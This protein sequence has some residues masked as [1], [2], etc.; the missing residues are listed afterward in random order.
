VGELDGLK[1][2][3]NE[4]DVVFQAQTKSVEKVVESSEKIS[5]TVDIFIDKQKEFNN[6]VKEVSMGKEILIE[7]IRNIATVGQEAFAIT[8]EVA[9]LTIGQRTVAD[10][11]LKISADICNKIN[12]MNKYSAKI[13]I[14]SLDKKRKKIAMIWDLES[15]FWDPATKEAHKAAKV[16]DFEISIFA[17][18]VRG[19]QGT[20]QM[21]EHLEE[22]IEQKYDAIVISPITNEKITQV[23][24]KATNQGIKI[25]FIQSVVEGV[26]YEAL[27]G[28][29]GF[30]CGINAARVAKRLLNNE[31]QAVIGM[32]AD[33]KLKAIEERAQGFIKELQQNSDI[34]VIQTDVVGEP[35]ESKAEDIIREMLRKH[36]NIDL[37]YATNVGWGMAYAKYVSK[38]HPNIKVVTVD[39][40]KDIAS[41]IH[42]GNID[43][44]IA[45]RP[46]IWG[47]KA[48]EILVDVFNGKSL[49][50]S[51]DT[52]TYEVNAKNIAIF[53]NRF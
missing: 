22:V 25:I 49:K 39:F 3:I 45:Q 9:S 8:E 44:A 5:G 4:S 26:P 31:G 11:L 47:S 6:E 15:P 28:T 43:I 18:K 24:K 35:S 38:Y 17:P 21:L 33:N 52:G 48:L 20:K 29:N 51:I 13:K 40:T 50:A 23:L 30:E 19:D 32:W 16:F 12:L 27:I 37:V 14:N 1:K 46:F 36:P 7:S 42:K 53:E 10:T 41:H 2:V 34:K